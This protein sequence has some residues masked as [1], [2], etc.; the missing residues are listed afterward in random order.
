MIAYLIEVLAFQLLFLLVYALFLKKETFFNWNRAYLL[1]TPLAGIL[2]PFIEFETVREVIPATYTY[3]FPV[4]METQV[5]ELTAGESTSSLQLSWMSLLYFGALISFLWFCS[6]F[7]RIITLI[8]KGELHSFKGFKKVILSE[9]NVAFSF[10]NYIFLGTETIKKPHQHIIDHELVHIRQ[11]HTWDLL[12]FEIL[13]IVFWYD[14][15]IYVYQK[16][17]AELHEFIAD[18]QVSKEGKSAHYD[19]LLQEVFQVKEV[20]FVN[21]FFNHSL[22]KKRIMMLA[23]QR[24]KNIFKLKYLLMIP[25]FMGILIYTSCEEK[26]TT[27]IKTEIDTFEQPVD[28]VVPFALVEEAPIFPGCE[29]S[30]DKRQCFQDKIHEHILSNFKYPGAAQKAGIEGRVYVQFTVSEKGTLTNVK[31]RGPDSSLEDEA[32]R[33]ISLLPVDFVPGKSKGKAVSVPFSIPITFKINGHNDVNESIK[34]KSNLIQDTIHI[35]F[36]VIDEVPVFP[37]CE[38]ASDKR[39]CF[40]EKMEAFVQANLQYPEPAIKAGIQGKVYIQ[41]VIGKEGEI[42]IL[43]VRGPVKDLE[44]EAKRIIGSL[45]K[46]VP[47]VHKGEPVLVPYAMP[48]TFQL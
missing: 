33:I 25:V 6:K 26:S 13:R 35:P 22:I 11:K 17:M 32:K 46:F 37:G 7:Y 24:S 18:A 21:Q 41:F 23:R 15:L 48:I 34:Q 38:D 28:R 19:Q 4:V 16:R 8:R 27:G 29:D 42:A 2:L 30:D 40:R 12:Y 20:S 5:S 47:G 1:V 39:A 10:F 43:R 44:E 45:P 9:S 36:A 14:P 3:S 31:M